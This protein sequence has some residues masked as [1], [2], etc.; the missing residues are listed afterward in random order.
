MTLL[1]VHRRLLEGRR[2]SMDLVGPGALDLHYADAKRS[3]AHL[4]PTG[5]WA[6]L[7]SGA[8]FPGIVLAALWPEVA[9]DLV[10]S[11]QKRATFLESVLLEAPERPA[12]IRV[13]N[14]RAETLPAASYDGVVAR[15]FL[16]PAE[17]LV[18]AARLLVPGGRAVVFLGA[19]ESWTPPAEWV[20]ERENSYSI[21]A[22]P[23]RAL[24]LRK[25]A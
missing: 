16:P 18:H 3:L 24:F 12:P 8:G 5:R 11:R 15:A 4:D 23:R 20:V 14:V 21:D 25:P 7:G 9:V 19:S 10:E 22:K 1:D 17:Y 2:H 13:L 6:D